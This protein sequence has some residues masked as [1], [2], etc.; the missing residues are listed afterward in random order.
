MIYIIKKLEDA[1]LGAVPESYEGK[2]YSLQ[3]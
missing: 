1:I 2:Y 3:V